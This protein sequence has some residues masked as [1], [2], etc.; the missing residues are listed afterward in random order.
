MSAGV[1]KTQGTRYGVESFVAVMA[2]RGVASRDGRRTARACRR[3]TRRQFFS[4]EGDLDV[5]SGF[6]NK[7][8]RNR[9]K[10][11]QI[12]SELMHLKRQAVELYLEGLG[13]RSIG[14]FL[15][16]SHVAV[17]QWI[18]GF[19]EKL[20]ELRSAH[21]IEIVEMDEIHTHIGS[22]KLVLDLDCYDRAGQKFIQC[23]FGSRD[24]ATGR[25]LWEKMDDKDIGAVMTDYWTPYEH[26]STAGKTHAVEG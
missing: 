9:F 26:F 16:V 25:T 20:E 22:K 1:D 5:P 6:A 3:H 7:W 8:R 11:C 18:G 17:Y 2:R 12:K 23:A 24:T 4:P 15:K 19:G 21:A 13:F 10:N 14:R